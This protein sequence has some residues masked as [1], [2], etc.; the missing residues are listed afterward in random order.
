MRELTDDYTSP[1]SAG[2]MLDGLRDLDRDL[3]EHMSKENLVLFP[4]ALVVQKE[5]GQS[6]LLQS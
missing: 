3:R 5:A 2:E 1:V 6:T 4:R